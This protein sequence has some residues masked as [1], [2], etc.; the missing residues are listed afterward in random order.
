MGDLLKVSAPSTPPTSVDSGGTV[1][2]LSTLAAASSFVRVGAALVSGFTGITGFVYV[3]PS[4]DDTTGARNSLALP[5]Q[6]IARALTISSAGDTIF[7]APGTYTENVSWPGATRSL[8]G[9]GSRVSIISGTFGLTATANGNAETMNISDVQ[10]T[11]VG[12]ITFAAKT[13]GDVAME[14]RGCILGSAW[15]FTRRRRVIIHTSRTPRRR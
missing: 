15:T 11:G 8:M 6:T 3:S 7:L 14:M 12:T 2:T 9:C 1:L 5:C 13:G 10:V 4:G